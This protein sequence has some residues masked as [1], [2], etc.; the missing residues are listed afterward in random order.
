MSESLRTKGTVSF[1]ID[2]GLEIVQC[3]KLVPMAYVSPSPIAQSA[4]RGWLLTT[5][6]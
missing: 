1:I 4:E 3:K 6:V 5:R 2:K